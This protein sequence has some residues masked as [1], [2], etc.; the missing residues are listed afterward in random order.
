MLKVFK[1][2]KLQRL[3]VLMESIFKHSM[4]SGWSEEQ[5]VTG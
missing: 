1:N 3:M 5:N 4:S 2:I